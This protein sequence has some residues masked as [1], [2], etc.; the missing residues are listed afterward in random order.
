M[1]ASRSKLIFMKI[2]FVIPAY[3]EEDYIANCLDALSEQLKGYPPEVYEII[4]V[5]NAS[6]D[7][8]AVIARS[9]P[10]VKIVDE[11]KKGLVNARKA[12]YLAAQGEL[13]A[14]IDADT[15]MP[16]GW[17]MKALGAFARDKR[18]V[19]YSGPFIYYDLPDAFNIFVRIHYYNGYF[20]S[21]IFRIFTRTGSMLQG[22]NFILRRSAF[23]KAGGYD[24]ADKFDFYGEDTYVARRMDRVGKVIFSFDFPMYA[25]GRR[26]KNEGILISGAKY[27]INY[28]WTIFFK[29]PFSRD[30]ADIRNKNL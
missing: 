15:I 10:R 17:I 25:S 3:N 21:R 29:K 28:V 1:A 14:N 8:T 24:D 16:A 12:G 20:W 19:A 6:T 4:V 26:I 5:N 13:V 18:L 30:Y 23:E 22:G 7:H 9:Y 2:S 11:P 27:A